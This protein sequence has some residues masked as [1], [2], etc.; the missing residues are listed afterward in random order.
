MAKK[1][2]DAPKGVSGNAASQSLDAAK[3]CD[4]AGVAD[5]RPS[6]SDRVQSAK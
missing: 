3:K 5:S 6:N 4:S 2:S 1:P